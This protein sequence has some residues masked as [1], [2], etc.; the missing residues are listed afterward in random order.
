MAMRVIFCLHRVT[1]GMDPMDLDDR[2]I[3]CTWS[4][5]TSTW[6]FHRIREDKTDP[7]AV[8]VYAKVPC[9]FDC[10]VAAEVLIQSPPR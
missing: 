2:I 1:Q 4:N 3:E 6:L 10:A 8:H 7:N 5:E 9:T